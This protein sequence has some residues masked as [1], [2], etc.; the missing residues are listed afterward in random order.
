MVLPATTPEQIDAALRAVSGR[1]ELA[2]PQKRFRVIGALVVGGI[3]CGI[4]A[5]A[6]WYS[7]GNPV[8]I[9]FAVLAIITSA[10]DLL[11]LQRVIEIDPAFV[12]YR[13]PL[14][15]LCWSIPSSE[16]RLIDVDLGQKEDL[17]RL[18]TRTSGKRRLPIPT[19]VGARLR[20]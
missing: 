18:V 10:Y 13:M 3:V 8:L 15:F 12:A 6:A 14:R 17:L 11:K 20:A 4:F 2:G 1:Y 5:F 7:D 9:A 19:S 16:L